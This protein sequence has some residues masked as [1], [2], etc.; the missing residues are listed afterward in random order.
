MKTEIEF[1]T[2]I[3][4]VG[5]DP[6][7]VYYHTGEQIHL[8]R[9]YARASKCPQIIID[10]TGSVVSNFK[11]YDSERTKYIFLYEA[12]V[13]DQ[14]N[15]FSFTVTNM[16][17]ERHSNVAIFNWLAN[18]K[19]SDVPMPK[20]TV[21]DQSLAIL[22]AVVQCFTQ[23]SS[24]Q[25]YINAC[26]DLILNNLPTNNHWIPRCFIRTD[27]AHFLKLI[28]K[29]PPLKTVARRVREVILRSL[30]MLIRSKSLEEMFSLLLSLFI[31]PTY[32]TDGTDTISGEKTPC[33][34]HK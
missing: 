24:L 16:L 18:W 29:W 25:D 15:E 32:E 8:Y 2:V 7:Y 4:D 27:I 9:N 11:K 31:V 17:S 1:K 3:H 30:C 13:Y 12:L 10:A 28:T 20:M 5:L 33:E 26:S 23:Y 6:F 34:T 21:C 14:E 22:S 19:K